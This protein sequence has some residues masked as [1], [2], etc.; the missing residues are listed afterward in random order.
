[1]P[2]G[3]PRTPPPGVVRARQAQAGLAPN[4]QAPGSPGP[5]IT[6]ASTPGVGPQIASGAPPAPGAGAGGPTV[7]IAQPPGQ[8]YGQRQQLEGIQQAVPVPDEAA[9][10]QAAIQSLSRMRPPTPLTAPTERPGVPLTNGLP[11]GAGAGPEILRVNQ[12]PRPIARM[13][14]LY[15]TL[16]A[17]TGDDR[18]RRAGERA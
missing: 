12:G 3:A 2:R 11:I 7:N 16:A 10:Y 6:P 4:P 13:A 9:R 18:L 15:N 1:V 14:D 5:P 8:P 17:I